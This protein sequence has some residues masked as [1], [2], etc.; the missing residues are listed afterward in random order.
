MRTGLESTLLRIELGTLEVK[1]EW[2]DHYTTEAPKLLFIVEYCYLL[3]AI[4]DSILYKYD[5]FISF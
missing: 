4:V 1:G 2:F 3:T 5:N